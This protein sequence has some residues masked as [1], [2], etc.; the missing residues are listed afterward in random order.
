M[1]SH[2]TLSLDAIS[3]VKSLIVVDPSSFA[4]PQAQFH[5][6]SRSTDGELHGYASMQAVEE[7]SEGSFGWDRR[8]C[9]ET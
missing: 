4:A 5:V 9:T 6:P 7:S 1:I 3:L 2:V 8:R